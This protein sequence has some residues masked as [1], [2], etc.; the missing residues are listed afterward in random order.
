MKYDVLISFTDDA[1]KKAATGENEYWAGVNQYPRNG[2]DPPEERIKFLLSENTCF[3]K[4]V[5][6]P[7]KAQSKK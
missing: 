5:I 7:A 3:K 4:P 2:Y 6:A 1:D